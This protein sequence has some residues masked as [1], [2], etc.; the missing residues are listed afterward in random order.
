MSFSVT[1][2]GEIINQKDIS[3]ILDDLKIWM[4]YDGGKLSLSD[5]EL[6]YNS[7]G[8]FKGYG[9]I[10]KFNDHI[11]SYEGEWGTYNFIWLNR[12]FKYELCIVKLRDISDAIQI[13]TSEIDSSKCQNPYY[14]FTPQTF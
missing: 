11:L 7:Y 12:S 4:H 1:E 8:E 9:S 14:V 13:I 5:A 10:I 3:G 6:H 2:S